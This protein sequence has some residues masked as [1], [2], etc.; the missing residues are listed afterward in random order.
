MA[1]GNKLFK[2]KQLEFEL[3]VLCN[4]PESVAHSNYYQ[5]IN[6]SVRQSISQSRH[7]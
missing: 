6:Q 7:I 4:W 1:S 3:N 2:V 5:S